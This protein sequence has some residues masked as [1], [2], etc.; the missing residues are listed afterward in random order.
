[1]ARIHD[2]SNLSTIS[3]MNN[4]NNIMSK[5]NENKI[6]ALINNHEQTY[7]SKLVNREFNNDSPFACENCKV[8]LNKQKNIFKEFYQVFIKFKKAA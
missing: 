2:I 8:D 7:A 3:S 1:M 5:N 6:N 4:N